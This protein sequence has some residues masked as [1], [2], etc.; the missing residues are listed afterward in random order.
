VNALDV[1]RALSRERGVREAY[2]AEIALAHGSNT[3]LDAA[4]TDLERD[5]REAS[6]DAYRARAIV[7]RMAVV[8]QAALLVRFA[9]AYVADA[10]CAARLGSAAGGYVYGALPRG[11]DTRSIVE[12]AAPRGELR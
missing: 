2:I 11:I 10:F 6:D 9:P 4:A 1:L 3:G 5:L 7:S 12:R 8:M